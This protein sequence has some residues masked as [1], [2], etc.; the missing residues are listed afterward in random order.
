MV[1][2]TDCEMTD[3]ELV[4][5]T[6]KISTK[7][8]QK[9]VSVSASITPDQ[10]ERLKALTKPLRFRFEQN[11]SAKT[12]HLI[13]PS[14]EDRIAPEETAYFEALV[15]GAWIVTWDWMEESAKSGDFVDEEEFLAV[16]T[17]GYRNG[18][19]EKS[20]NNELLQQPKLF[21]GFHVFLEG[22]FGK[23]YPSAQDLTKVRL[24]LS[25]APRKKS[26]REKILK[27]NNRKSD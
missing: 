2:Q 14:S 5:Q 13:V 26:Q 10:V 9:T 25:M 15:L 4:N 18:A 17:R 21:K 22:N 8:T 6:L 3:S 1:E 19:P 11:V 27:C 20:R 16:G 23:P 7:P 12:T 24:D